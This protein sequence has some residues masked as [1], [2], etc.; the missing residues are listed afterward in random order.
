VI[1]K[2]EKFRSRVESLRDKYFPQSNLRI[3][4]ERMNFL[5]MR[6]FFREELFLDIYYNSMND[7]T[8]FALIE[9]GKGIFGCDNLGGWHIHPFNNPDRHE[10]C[11]EPEI[12]MCEDRLVVITTWRGTK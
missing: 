11:K 3:I 1:E 12:E 6:I 10:S 5:K 7:R 8:D 9:H 4:N 2:R